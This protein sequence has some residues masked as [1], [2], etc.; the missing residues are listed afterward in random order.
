[1]ILT[2]IQVNWTFGSGEEA[3][4]KKKKKKKKKHTQKK[5]KKRKKKGFQDGRYEGHFGFPVKPVLA[6]LIYQP[7]LCFLPNFE[8]IGLSV[9]K[10]KQKVD[11]GCLGVLIRT[12][13]FIYFLIY[14]SPQSFLLR[15]ESTG[16][17]VQKMRKLDFSRWSLCH[18][19]FPIGTILC[20]FYLTVTPMLLTK[21]QVNLPFASGEEAKNRFF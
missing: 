2:E 19:G 9:Q 3:K 1:M 14:K 5:K 15:F 18:L 6:I 12:F 7:P 16:L 13:F 21:F 11:G 10:K 8:S 17:S 20:T 4:K